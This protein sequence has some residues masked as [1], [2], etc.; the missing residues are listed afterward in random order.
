MSKSSPQI[1]ADIMTRNVETL[2]PADDVDLADMLMRLD[3]VH[4]L[5]VIEDGQL[6][7]LVSQ[8]D[9]ARIQ[10]SPTSGLTVEAQR[11]A[12]LQVKVRDMMVAD[13]MTA[14]ST[15]SILEAA[16][17]MK[18]RYFGCLPVVDDGE[19]V[20]IVTGTDMLGAFITVLERV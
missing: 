10:V 15:T 8:R 16:K 20:G 11:R 7:G 19:L 3:R 4:H 6:V 18:E 2:D 17:L 13:V 5:P 14:P 12:H 9:I 1:I